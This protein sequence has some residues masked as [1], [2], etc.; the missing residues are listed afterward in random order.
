MHNTM[1]RV[2]LAAGVAQRADD[3]SSTA[4]APDGVQPP[5]RTATSTVTISD[6]HTLDAVFRSMFILQTAASQLTMD[7]RRAGQILTPAPS[8]VTRP[9]L[10]DHGTAFWADTIASLACRGNAYWKRYAGSDGTT[11]S[12]RVLNPL[13]VT[14]WRN[15]YDEVRYSWRGKDYTPGQADG[16]AHLKLLRVPG[17][18]YGLGPIQAAARGLAG[19]LRVSAYGDQW[20]DTSDIPGG[21]LTTEQALTPTQAGEWKQQ[22]STTVKAGE[23]AVLGAGLDYK[24][25]MLTPAE[26]QW[27]E[28]QKFSTTSIARWFGIPARLMLAAVDGNSLTYMNAM[29]EDIAFNRYTLMRYLREAEAVMTD[30]L[31][32]GQEARFNVDALLRADTK[33]RYETHKIGIEAGF[34]SV[35]EVRAV[36]GLTGPAPEK[37]AADPAQPAQIGN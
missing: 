27:L 12:C 9:D 14:V 30:I 15:K 4:T 2:L 3:T 16:I 36:E 6:A 25:L 11:V 22:W 7:V 10:A 21:I 20:F 31:P 35:E 34:V 32:R 33:T 23:T 29:S 1:K 26:A 19:M 24:A 13:D 18:L 8:L 17:E 28:S 5:W 37:P